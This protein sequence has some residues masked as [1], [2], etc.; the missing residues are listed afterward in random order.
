VYINPHDV[1][2][3]SP[4]RKSACVSSGSRSDAGSLLCGQCDE[5]PARCAGYTGCAVSICHGEHLLAHVL[6]AGL[7]PS[8]TATL[9]EGI[10]QRAIQLQSLLLIKDGCHGEQLCICPSHLP[11]TIVPHSKLLV[12][13]LSV[14]EFQR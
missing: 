2:S 11:Q 9:H 7:V 1:I 10:S 5:H 14:P 13:T 6:H 12:L 3:S 8:G 4:C